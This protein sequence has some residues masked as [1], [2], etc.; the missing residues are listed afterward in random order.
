MRGTRVRMR[1]A[2]AKAKARAKAGADTLPPGSSTSQPE[3]Q[4]PAPPWTGYIPLFA[5]IALSFIGI[6]KLR[7]FMR[8]ASI[9][10]GVVLVLF[11]FARAF[12]ES[13][14]AKQMSAKVD[15]I[16]ET[17]GT[18]ATLESARETISKPFKA[19]LEVVGKAKDAIRHAEESQKAKV[20]VL[21]Q[22][23]E[24]D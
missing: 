18:K 1:G 11:G 13:S 22:L 9:G 23:T 6:A 17:T 4:A 5:G 24:D 14:A 7:G 19:P 8:L 16:A 2:M 15:E 12:P 3:A 20:R 10:L 21:D